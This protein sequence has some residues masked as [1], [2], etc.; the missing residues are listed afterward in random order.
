MQ[1]ESPHVSIRKSAKIFY[2]G[3]YWKVAEL[4]DKWNRNNPFNAFDA[5]QID[6][7]A[8]APKNGDWEE[9]QK[10]FPAYKNLIAGAYDQ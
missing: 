4:A 7:T 8:I 2:M 9:F 3:F 5:K 10:E 6:L 1:P